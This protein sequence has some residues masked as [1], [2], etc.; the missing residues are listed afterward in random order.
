MRVK[1]QH[2]GLFRPFVLWVLGICAALVVIFNMVF[3]LQTASELTH[4]AHNN[5]QDKAMAVS[6]LVLNRE[7]KE[8][9]ENLSTTGINVHGFQYVFICTINCCGTT[10]FFYSWTNFFRF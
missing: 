1:R 5:Q 3:V 6:S 10:A 8:R 7:V 9:V 4:L 2:H